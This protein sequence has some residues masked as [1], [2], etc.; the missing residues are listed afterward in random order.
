[1][2][3]EVSNSI[4]GSVP[5][6]LKDS[7][8]MTRRDTNN[9]QSQSTAMLEALK[10][11]WPEY[12]IEGLGICFFMLS[13]CSFATFLFHPSSPMSQLLAG[14]YW[15]RVLMGFAMGLT[16]VAII[17]S[18]LGKRSGAHINPATTLMFFRLGKIKGWDLLLYTAAQFA[19]AVIGVMGSIVIL[20][21]RVADPSVNYV[22][23]IPGPYGLAAA[24]LAELTISFILMS[25]VLTVSNTARYDRWTGVVVGILVMSYI[26]IE[27]PV[28]GMS[29]NPARTFGSALPASA[30]T[31]WWIYFIAPP[32]GMLLAAEIYVRIKGSHAAVKCAKMHHRNNQRCIFRCGYKEQESGS[33]K[34]LSI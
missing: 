8:Q 28:S 11:H 32:L 12:L 24:F 16:A 14:S 30:W 19:G 20:G 15:Q 22:A 3:M 25:A 27:S 5:A 10:N 9:C 34:S 2:K 4:A 26:S 13:A 18:P 21:F 23:T 31:G 33:R 29:M 7:S 17:Y 1:M 6:N